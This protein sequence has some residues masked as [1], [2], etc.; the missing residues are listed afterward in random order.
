MVTHELLVCRASF[1][2]NYCNFVTVVE[3]LYVIKYIKKMVLLRK[4]KIV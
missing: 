3:V 4:K 1:H 2:A